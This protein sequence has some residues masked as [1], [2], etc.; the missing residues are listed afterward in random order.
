MEE[1]T[2]AEAYPESWD[3]HAQASAESDNELKLKHG[4]NVRVHIVSGPLTFREE[5]FSLGAKDKQGKDKKTRIAIPFGS[6]L[7]GYK[8]K[9]RYMSEVVIL[10]GAAKGMNKI[11]QFGKQV[12][13]DLAKIKDVWGS[14][15]T[16]DI[17]LSRTGTTKDDTKYSATAAPATVQSKDLKV[18]F[19]LEKEVRYSTKEDIDKLPP[20]PVGRESAD[21]ISGH[22][23]HAQLDLIDSLCKEKEIG[24]AELKKLVDRKAPGKSLTELTT[25]QASMV[26]DLLKNY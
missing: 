22:V 8:M 18:K 6:Q 9:V 13:D 25:G 21:S 5:Y 14:T 4:D 16:P 3:E 15:R 11:F 1:S 2:V 12:A 17:V 26:I 7:P 19:N 10:D 23:S 20:P 24:T